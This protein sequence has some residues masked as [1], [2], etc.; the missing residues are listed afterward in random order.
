MS[1]DYELDDFLPTSRQ[2][3]FVL[4]N[5]LPKI[6]ADE[7]VLVCTYVSEINTDDPEALPDR[8]CL[9]RRGHEGVHIGGYYR[10]ERPE[11]QPWESTD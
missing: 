10:P 8:I 11:E 1:D 2:L 5:E 9:V 3:I 7:S 4:D 6:L